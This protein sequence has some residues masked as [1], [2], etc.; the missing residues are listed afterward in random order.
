MAKLEYSYYPGCS[1]ESTSREYDMSMRTLAKLLDVDLIELDDW[2]CCGASSGHY[3]NTEL[4]LAL[5]ARNLAIAEK[6]GR[7]LAIACAACF[8]RLKQSNH[9]LLANGEL[10]KEVEQA[11]G[12]PFKGTVKVRHLLDI[13][14][15]DVGVEEIEKR[16][17]KPLKGLKLAAYYGCYLIRPPK[18]SQLDDPENPTIME[19]ILEAAGAETVDWT[20][21]VECCGGNLMLSRT[22]MVVKLSTNVCDAAVKAGAD[23]IVTA[24]P[25]C[26]V[27]LDTR[28]AGAETIPVIQF[29]ELLGLALG[30]EQKEVHSWFKKHIVDPSPVLKSAGLV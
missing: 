3:T 14:A 21:K 15:N 13:F 1:L 8:L 10:R 22:D 16:V 23:A 29:S 30:T 6:D 26:Q 7:D 2:N 27:N 12:M 9:E 25:L 28:Q 18:I 4:S 24:C 19:R 11:L 20:H 17:K 5:P